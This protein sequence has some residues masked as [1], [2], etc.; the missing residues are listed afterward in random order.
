MDYEKA[1]QFWIEKD[2]DSVKMPKEELR[3]EIEE[4]LKKRSV[5]ALATADKDFVRSTPIAY[6]YI[7]GYFYLFSEGGRKFKAL[8]ENKN[9]SLSVFDPVVS[10]TE[11]H[12]LQV[13]GKAEILEQDCEEYLRI[14]SYKHLSLEA[15]KKLSHPLYLIKITPTVFDLLDS[16]LK[17]K[18]YSSRQEFVVEENK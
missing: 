10:F 2:K 13:M 1:S 14:A 15:L 7:D 18:G 12:S 6:N 11:L 5:C 16:D 17:K 9:V 4:F 8:K 3:K